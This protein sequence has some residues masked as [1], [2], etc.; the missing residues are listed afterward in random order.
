MPARLRA[1]VRAL[2]ESIATLEQSGASVD[3]DVLLTLARACRDTVRV[4]FDYRA[5]DGTTTRRRVEPYRL[6]VV[7]PRWYLFAYDL[8]R[9]DWRTF[10]LDRF[11]TVAP[12]T[13][14]F[15]PREHD[16]PASYVQ[17]S[18]VSSPYQHT[19]RAVVHAPAEVVAG[20]VT[21]GSAAVEPV[22]DRTC[23]LVSG[24]DSLDA[25]AFHL[26]WLGHDFD[27]LEPE[28][29]RDALADLGHRMLRASG[30]RENDAHADEPAGGV[31]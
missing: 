23:L 19:A 6:V 24:G 3:G 12:G 27:V 5:H 31:Q 2:Q 21:A 10:R 22:D 13:W 20:K 30:V 28:A 1:E 8:D 7:G 16:D 9:D 18:V 26:T 29:L 15:T 14:R 11:G 25:I 17:R 4:G